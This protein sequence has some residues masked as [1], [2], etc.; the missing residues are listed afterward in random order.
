MKL[1]N[2]SRYPVASSS[3]PRDCLWLSMRVTPS[4][5]RRGEKRESFR[6]SVMAVPLDWIE[7]AI[8]AGI[9]LLLEILPQRKKNQPLLP[10]SRQSTIRVQHSH[11]LVITLTDYL[12][13]SYGQGS[14]QP[15]Y[16]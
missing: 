1:I 14:S 2:L 3:I 15:Y 4:S 10:F 12:L 7:R 11:R 16:L 13:L 9:I 5:T 8:A 6:G